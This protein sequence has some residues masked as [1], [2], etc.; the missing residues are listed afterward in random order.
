MTRRDS[1]GRGKPGTLAVIEHLG[2]V[3]IDTISVVERAH[4]HVLH[5]RVSSYQPRHLQSLVAQGKVFEYWSHAAAYLPMRDFRYSLPMKKG[6]REGRIRAIKS[7]DDKLIRDLKARIRSEGPLRSR[8]ID[9]DTS[10]SGGWWNWKPAKRALEHMFLRG[11][12]MITQRDGFQKTYDLPERVI[13]S[14]VDVSE[15]TPDEYAAFLLNQQLDCHGFVSLKGVSYAR[16]DSALRDAVKR[17]VNDRLASSRLIWLTLPSGAK[18][19]AR[20]DLIDSNKPRTDQRV[21][22]LSPFDNLVIQRE[23]VEHLFDFEYQIECYVPQA[24]R[25]YG[26]FCLPLHYG[27]EFVGRMDCKAHRKTGV[28]EIRALHFEPR[29]RPAGSFVEA[30]ARALEHF[31]GFQGCDEI[32]LPGILPADL[33]SALEG[34]LARTP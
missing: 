21:R 28:L 34:A 25:K 33:T 15:P 10:Q 27:D 30:F 1:F 12:L 8:D 11:E 32:A 3:Q 9:D 13:P 22:I 5:S 19:L 16:R 14:E 26:Y 18:Y 2:Y 4:H 20:P 17:L 24:Q 29:F 7:V 6:V 23:R 31:A